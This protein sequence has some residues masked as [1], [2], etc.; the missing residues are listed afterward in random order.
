MCCESS[1][2]ERIAREWISVPE[3]VTFKVKDRDVHA[4]YYP[5]T[6]PDVDAR[7]RATGRRCW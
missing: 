2:S 7:R 6:N 5:P 4:F 1:A 3:A